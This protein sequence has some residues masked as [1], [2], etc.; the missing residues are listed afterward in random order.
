MYMIGGMRAKMEN[1]LEVARLGIDVFI[2]NPLSD[3]CIL[4]C[5]GKKVTILSY[6]PQSLPR[7]TVI[8]IRINLGNINV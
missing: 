1:A 4:A 6:L 2:V 3:D 8:I 5:Q 7:A